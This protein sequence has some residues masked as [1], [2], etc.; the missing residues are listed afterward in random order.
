MPVT[1]TIDRADH[2]VRLTLTGVMSIDEMRRMVDTIV[3]EVGDEGGYCVLS[4]HRGLSTPSTPAQLEALVDY[5]HI[6]GRPF[7]RARWAVVTSNPASY[8]MMCLL[9][10]IAE[11]VPI[12]VNVFEDLES[13]ETWLRTSR[14]T[15]GG[16]EEVY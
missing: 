13:A 4:D 7:H 11:R 9:M 8:G 2:T 3:A 12:L 16:L 1:Y 6:A 10:V 15:V 14:E 5:L